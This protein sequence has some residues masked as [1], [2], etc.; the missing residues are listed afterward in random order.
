LATGIVFDIKKFSIHDGPGIRT[1]VFLKGCPL[2][3]WWCHNPES[4]RL[5][6]EVMLRMD[7]CIQCAACLELCEQGAISLNS[8]GVVTDRELCIQCGACAQT[9]YADAREVI[10]REMTVAEV[11]AEIMRD[12]SFYDESGG[13]VTFSGGDPLVQRDFLLDLLK[14]CKQQEIHTAVDSSGSFAWPILERIRPYVDLFLYDVK[15]MDEERHIEVTGVS[16]RLI[17]ENLRKLSQQGQPII[18]RMAVV[19]GIND[20]VQ[21]LR[22]T[23]EFAAA[24]PHLQGVSLLPYHDTAV[25]KYANLN[26]AYA[27]PDIRPP[28]EEKMADIAATLRGY[29]LDVKIGG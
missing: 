9:C 23:G 21:N 7:R 3:C 27:I 16:N 14:A 26:R 24:L 4:Q 8:G 13:G 25:H 22:R 20:D 10:G 19:P 12:L 2:S 1:T 28:T 15:T 17:L 11:M 5:K 6:P 18:L 29:G